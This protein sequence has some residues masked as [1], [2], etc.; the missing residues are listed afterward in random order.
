MPKA[1]KRL[2]R[3]NGFLY[4]LYNL[5]RLFKGYFPIFL[6]YPFEPAPRYGYGKPAHA[7]LEAM[8]AAGAD[9]YRQQLREFLR[10]E[11]Q[12]ARIPARVTEKDTRAS[13]DPCWINRWLD[14]LD[15]F[16][17]YGF[18]ASRRPK[19]YLEIGSGYSTKVVR[20]AV[21]D[22][23]LATR[24]V[25]VDPHPRAEIDALCDELVRSNMQSL[26]LERFDALNAGDILFVDGSHRVFMNS[27]VAVL[28]LDVL[29]RLRP[30]V[31]VHI[32]DV[33]LPVDYPPR[34]ADWYY[35]EQYM[36]A[37]ELLAGHAGFRVV[38]P[39]QYA[40]TRPD[41]AA[42]LDG[43]WSRPEMKDVPRGGTSFWLEITAK[44]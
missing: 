24:I 35:S 33:Y 38:L 36:L 41:I 8:F 39:G 9:A 27:D 14:G 16:A 4:V 15:T 6:D 13:T 28:F 42:V 3:R 26:P 31:L 40:A 25:S 32:H 19:L 22:S 44:V 7:Q 34:M 43:F 20:R 5:P 12:L 1:L 17:L 2:A 23:D 18:I 37:A 21:R 29:P 30:G 10:F 11:E